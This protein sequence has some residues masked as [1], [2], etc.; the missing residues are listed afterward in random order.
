MFDLRDVMS[1]FADGN[2]TIKRFIDG[3]LIIIATKQN[4][5]A[6]KRRGDF[7]ELE[8]KDHQTFYFIGSCNLIE[9]LDLVKIKAKTYIVMQDRDQGLAGIAT[10]TLLFDVSNPTSIDLLSEYKLSFSGT[11]T[12]VGPGS[13]PDTIIFH[14]KEHGLQLGFIVSIF[15]RYLSNKPVIALTADSF[16]IAGTY[17]FSDKG[18]WL[19]P[20]P[21]PVRVIDLGIGEQDL[22]VA[23]PGKT[24]KQRFRLFIWRHLISRSLLNNQ[25]LL[26]KLTDPRNIRSVQPLERKF[27]GGLFYQVIAQVT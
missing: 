9:V 21:L 14:S 7:A 18:E 4:L 24:Y 16:T 17:T 20:L 6:K 27:N 5:A 23:E 26:W 12:S 22:I 1:V 19:Y 2:A 10:G 8:L 15:G 3:T 25:R 13:A 11:F